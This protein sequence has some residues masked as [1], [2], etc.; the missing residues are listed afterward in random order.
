MFLTK[1]LLV[2]ETALANAISAYTLMLIRG[3]CNKKQ[4]KAMFNL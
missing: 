3:K 4:K 2:T 1:I